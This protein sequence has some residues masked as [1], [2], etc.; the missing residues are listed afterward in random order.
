[1]KK[2]LG[3]LLAVMLV[4]SFT[5]CGLKDEIKPLDVTDGD[6]MYEDDLYEFFDK[7]F[8]PLDKEDLAY[9]DQW[10]KV[11]ADC[12]TKTEN[13]YVDST[14]KINISGKI[15]FSKFEYQNK[16]KLT[17]KAVV[18][19]VEEDEEF[20]EEIEMTVISLKGEEFAKADIKYENEECTEKRTVY[21]D[22]VGE[23]ETN[24]FDGDE[25]FEMIN[26]VD[27]LFAYEE[28]PEIDVDDIYSED[29]KFYECGKRSFAMVGEMASE[30]AENIVQM[31]VVFT[32]KAKIDKLS[33]YNCYKGKEEGSK[34]ETSQRV[35][36]ERCNSGSVK[37]PKDL[38]KYVAGG[39]Y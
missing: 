11:N 26:I 7:L 12:V 32:K 10:Y 3:L 16:Y 5:A 17:V 38:K 33:M 31:K 6:R 35:E 39:R 34:N 1:M 18:E 37:A 24:Y 25:F 28:M 22:D 19:G 30:L 8:S 20:K 9:E 36:V 13:E 23:I 2:L 27:L 4:F 15:F 29:V 21:A 14:I